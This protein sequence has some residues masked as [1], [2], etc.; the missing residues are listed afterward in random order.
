MKHLALAI[1]QQQ[2]VSRSVS[3]QQMQE[4]IAGITYALESISSLELY[5]KSLKST[6]NVKETYRAAKL[7]LAE[8]A[9]SL[10]FLLTNHISTESMSDEM[11]R[12]VAIEG[13]SDFIENIWEAIK[14]AFKWLWDKITGLFSPNKD[15][16]RKKKEERL[17][18]LLKE[19]K[20]DFDKEVVIDSEKFKEKL[21]INKEL[22]GMF[23]GCDKQKI[24]SGDFLKMMKA[25]IDFHK[26]NI[27]ATKNPIQ[28]YIE[29]EKNFL[30]TD[31]EYIDPN[32]IGDVGSKFIFPRDSAATV[33]ILKPPYTENSTAVIEE[34]TKTL[35]DKKGLS[36]VSCSCYLFNGERFAFYTTDGDKE[37]L[38][39]SDAPQHYRNYIF[40]IYKKE[41]ENQ[42][43]EF[44]P[45][46]TSEIKKLVSDISSFIIDISENIMGY[47]GI[48][49]LEKTTNS[50]IEKGKNVPTKTTVDEYKQLY[51]ETLAYLVSYLQQFINLY[52]A[53]AANSEKC[54]DVCIAYLE[55]I[56]TAS[57]ASKA[58]D[59]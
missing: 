16:E 14:S 8:E 20:D 28:Q 26:S 45:V 23:S 30:K 54:I 40:S 31:E 24:E 10:N 48:E 38:V 59:S 46:D 7:A 41:T 29:A 42:T 35:R 3:L 11:L 1:E 37:Q 18:A 57:R 44:T 22:I 33:A 53:G 5:K 52:I 56:L 36:D 17:K 55:N 6:P 21:N 49:H 12:S 19:L 4:T 15:R 9:K 2:V 27:L 58:I 39:D 34:I 32:A 47:K 13:I 51:S 50:L 43:V 25:A